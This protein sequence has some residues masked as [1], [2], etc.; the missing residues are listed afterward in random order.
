M[1]ITPARVSRR[2]ADSVLTL[3]L[4]KNKVKYVRIHSNE[5]TTIDILQFMVS[6]RFWSKTSIAINNTIILI[7][8][9]YVELFKNRV[10]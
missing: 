9:C 4:H 10:P 6:E 8:T 7:F 2:G 1:V 5:L 3:P